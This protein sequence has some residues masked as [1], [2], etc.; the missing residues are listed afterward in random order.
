MPPHT[1][2]ALTRPLLI[3]LAL[4]L[5]TLTACSTPTPETPP[6]PTHTGTATSTN[7]GPPPPPAPPRP[8]FQSDWADC[9]L[10]G[11]P[12]R[13]CATLKVPVDA[14]KPDSGSTALAISRVPATDRRRRIGVLLI[15]PGGPGLQGRYT[16]AN[17]LPPQFRALF[18]IVGFDRRGSHASTPD[19]DCGEPGEAVEKL[20]EGNTLVP[21]SVD[22]TAVTAEVKKYAAACTKKYGPLTG[23]LGTKSAAQDVEAIRR[24]LEE[25]RISLLGISY[26][27]LLGQQYLATHPDRV[28]AAVLDGTADPDRTGPAEAVGSVLDLA[29]AGSARDKN[30][31][32]RQAEQ[33]RAALSGFLPWCRGAGPAECALA[34]NPLDAVT[35][36]FAKSPDLVRS[37]N[38]VSQDPALWPGFARAV[39]KASDSTAGATDDLRKFADR[40]A[41]ADLAQALRPVPNSLAFDLAN[42]CTDFRW[43]Q[44]TKALLDEVAA[45]AEKARNE[46]AGPSVAADFAP[47]AAWPG[48]GSPLGAVKAPS[49]PRPL[50]VSTEKDPRTPL[51][52]AEKVA[53]RLNAPLL[54][55][56]GDLHGVTTQGN[57]CVQA[58]LVRVLVE[59]SAPKAGK[60]PA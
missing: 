59:G 10:T 9:P 35:A 26:G 2:R 3:T 17:L 6:S 43:P 32:T 31:K 16:V 33:V 40:K 30:A 29:D 19:V 25:D 52:G 60:C 22:L 24:A 5:T 28:R 50:I 14:A 49:G 4:L 7:T 53:S 42:K 37:V 39:D 18:D 58:A 1:H 11:Q 46:P 56:G 44:D 8:E 41:P 57:E 27:T 36:V 45:T 13:E 55:V 47:C 21:T 15:D 51:A 23:H 48:T 34:E 20:R 12:T 54:K 38:A